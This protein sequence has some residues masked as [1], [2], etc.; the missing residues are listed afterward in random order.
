MAALSGNATLARLWRADPC[1]NPN[2][3]GIIGTP[4]IDLDSRALFLNAMTTPDGGNTV[5]H[6]IFSLNMDTGETNAGWPVDVGAV[7]IYNGT[8]FTPSIQFQRSALGIVG[9]ILYVPYGS[10]HDCGVYHG[11]LVGIPIN[12]PGGVMAWAPTAIGGG[13]WA[14]GGVAS[15]GTNAFIATGN[16]FNTGG[17]WGGG[18]AVIRFQPGPIFTGQPSDYWAPTNW[19]ALDI[20]NRDFCSGPLLVDVPGATPS[21]LIVVVG[22]DGN[23][24]LLDRGNLGGITA[25]V[26][27]SQVTDGSTIPAAATYRTG[28]G[29]YV[30]FRASSTMLSAFRITATNPPAIASA[31]SVPRNGRSSPFV[32]SSDGANDMIVWVVDNDGAGHQ[33]LHGFDGDTGN[34][35]YAGGGPNELMVGARKFNTGIAARGRI[36]IANDN[37]VYAF[38]GSSPTPTPTPTETPTATPTATATPTPSA[39]PTPRQHLPLPSK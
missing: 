25:P 17:T 13:I 21:N 10:L 12:N 2:P 5:K 9:G 20:G 30:A 34:V 27:S 7:A 18:E 1:G 32:T 39:T 3:A 33:L 8:T 14:G 35:V 38:V 31:W 16:T 24:Y 19:Y 4:I 6:L 22:K 23:A 36:Y 11:W 37:K 28:Q 29:S 26:T 15:D